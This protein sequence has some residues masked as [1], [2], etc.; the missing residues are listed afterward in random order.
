[1]PRGLGSASNDR[2]SFACSSTT[3]S[4]AATTWSL[5]PADRDRLFTLF[6]GRFFEA[7]PFVLP[8]AHYEAE[9][10]PPYLDLMICYVGLHYAKPMPADAGMLEAAVSSAL[11]SGH[12]EQSAYRVQALVLRAI[13]MHAGQRPTETASCVARAAGI[14]MSLGMND[15]FFARN[16]SHGSLVLEESL[17]RTWWELQ[18][19]DVYFAA[20]HR[21]ST[22][23][24]CSVQILPFL[25]CAES[26]Y[27]VGLCDQSQAE[28][29]AFD[30]RVFSTADSSLVYSSGCFR[31]E[32]I[33][34]VSRA[35][36]VASTDDAHPDAIQALDNAVAS[37]EYNLPEQCKDVF[38]PSG[39][40]DHML[41][42]GRCFI[43]CA[44]IFL[45]FPRS[46]LVSTV[47]SA[48][49]LECAKNYTQLTPTSRHHALKAIAASKE[50]ASLA[51]LPWP[52]GRHSP[53]V[54]CGLVLGC[55]VQLAAGIAHSQQYGLDGLQQHRDRVVLM[56]GALQGLSDIW[57]LAKN[58]VT[59]LR[60]IADTVFTRRN[61]E[62]PASDSSS[63]HDSAMDIG[64]GAFSDLSWFDLFSADEMQN[65]FFGS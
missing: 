3:A 31:I 64:S 63:F 14:A 51:T 32:A 13:V 15:P 2:S 44:S 59:S 62:P 27:R 23:E 16:E 43:L 49:G 40:L 47:P 55:I 33:R 65:T 26:S 1:M 4:P 54:I 7:H 34:I 18:A 39:E 48:G 53:F 41:F 5:R 28:I 52:V 29:G 46:N 25:P 22:F 20:L 56:L 42:E 57:K 8:R 6:Y 50:L 19:V 17:R 37:W 11:S 10:C 61:Q 9:A 24:T 58:A 12:D 45:H 60:A 36:A 30:D 35:L 38:D 21:R